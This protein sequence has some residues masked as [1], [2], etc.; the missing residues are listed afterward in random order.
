MTSTL[1]H[2]EPVGDAGAAWHVV[3]R[4]QDGSTCWHGHVQ[5]AHTCEVSQLSRH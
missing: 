5:R 4:L 2:T 1:M 3:P